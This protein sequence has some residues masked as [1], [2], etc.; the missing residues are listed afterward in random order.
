MPRAFAPEGRLD[1]RAILSGR[2]LAYAYPAGPRALDSVDVDVAPGELVVVIGPNGSGKSTLVKV[3]SGL[4]VPGRGTVTYAGRGLTD[5]DA[6]ERARR[7]ALVPQF[8]PALPEVSVSA[9]VTSGRYAHRLR[10]LSAALFGRALS[11]SDESAARAAL[12]ACDA[13]DLGDRAMTALS[14]GQ[15]QRVLIARAVAQDAAVLLVDE[16]TNALDPEHQIQVFQLIH[17]L[18]G[19]GR[20][21]L[22]VTHDLNLAG[23]FASRILLFDEGRVVLDAA[24]E[25]VLR[26]EVLEPVYG[27]HLEYLARPSGSSVRAPIVVPSRGVS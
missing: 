7:I 4:L 26:R 18:C 19:E 27:R 1:P 5:F 3:L 12:Q 21:A 11:A 17:T 14:G 9:F 15:R 24:P 8:L 23:Q 20:A 13:S 10:G 16:P 22:V 6:S 2:G 25:Q